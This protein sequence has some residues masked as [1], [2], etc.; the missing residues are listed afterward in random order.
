M[1]PRPVVSRSKLE[2][3]GT[4]R[5]RA[6]YRHYGQARPARFVC[7]FSHLPAGEMCSRPVHPSRLFARQLAWTRGKTGGEHQVE[8][9]VSYQPSTR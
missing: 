2:L 5:W 4:R 6:K 1:S 7:T 3:L 8:D 9:D